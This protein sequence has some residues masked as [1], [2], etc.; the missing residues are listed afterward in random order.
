MLRPEQL[1]I[2]ADQTGGSGCLGTVKEIDFGGSS[3]GLTIQLHG[4]QTV[5]H[6]LLV[7]CPNTQMPTVGAT[8]KMAPTGL[9]HVLDERI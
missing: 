5:N 2:S 1:Q 7:R 9:A 8:V 4:A 6:T 3:S